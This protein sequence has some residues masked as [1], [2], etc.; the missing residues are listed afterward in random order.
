MIAKE[1]ESVAEHIMRKFGR[2]PEQSEGMREMIRERAA[3]VGFAMN[4]SADSRIYNTFD[5][6][7]LIH[8][9][10]IEGSGRQRALK[11][12][13]FEL[14]FTEQRDPSDHQ[15]LIEAA[16]SAGLDPRAA[17]DVLASDLYSEEVR[18]AEHFWQSQGVHS[19]PAIVINDRYLISGGQPPEA[20]EK[21]LRSIAA[22]L[23]EA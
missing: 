14:Y 3:E 10:G 6:H 8:W 12:R 7:R 20:F 11:N 21:A 19:V 22:E 15:V 5:A 2:T 4:S 16:M 1:G 9:A 18:Q 17:A 23:A 13:L